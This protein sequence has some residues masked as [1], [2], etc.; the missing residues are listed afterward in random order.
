M[1][2]Q[3]VEHVG[4]ELVQEP[5]EPGEPRG[6]GRPG[7]HAEAADDDALD[8][9]VAHLDVES[10]TIETTMTSQ[11][12]RRTAREVARL[13]L[14]AADPHGR[15]EVQDARRPRARR[16]MRRSPRSPRRRPRLGV[17]VAGVRRGGRGRSSPEDEP[18]AGQHEAPEPG[19]RGA[20]GARRGG[21][22][23]IAGDRRPLRDVGVELPKRSRLARRRSAPTASTP[24]GRPTSG[25]SPPAPCSAR[26]TPDPRRPGRHSRRRRD[27]PGRRLTEDSP[28]HRGLAT[29]GALLEPEPAEEV[30]PGE[31]QE[32]ACEPAAQRVVVG[33]GSLAPLDRRRSCRRLGRRGTS[34]GPA[35]TGRPAG[36]S[37]PRATRWRRGA[38]CRR[39]RGSRT[40]PSDR[41]APRGRCSWRPSRPGSARDG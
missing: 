4:P 7:A 1:D 10:G 5:D 30:A 29:R 34:P 31:V 28:P 24:P 40:S 18:Q 3:A 41:P 2:H 32:V 9:E 38:A 12:R 39:C 19:R 21:R 17:D 22:G 11:P 23:A 13:L 33:D 6:S 16:L 35:S 26:P 8:L 20:R 36:R 14:G 25:G 37:P 15:R 27:E